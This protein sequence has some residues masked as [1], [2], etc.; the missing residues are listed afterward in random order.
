MDTKQYTTKE[1]LKRFVPYFRK[2]RVT[3]CMDL[4]CAALTTV[5]ELV[6][7]LIMRYITNEGLRDLTSLSFRT[8]G[9][10]GLLYLGLRI[11]DCIASYY[12]ADMG[13]VMG[14]RIET[15]MRRDAYG[16]LAEII[17]YLLQQYQSRTDYG[18]YYQ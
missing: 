9:A 17:Q 7:P 6:L 4:F 16:H 11:L 10:L 2:Y 3:L 1:L 8:V 14:A 18:A 12:M 13:H 5:C 15:D